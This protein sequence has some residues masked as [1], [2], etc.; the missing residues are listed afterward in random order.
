MKDAKPV[1]VLIG[2]TTIAATLAFTTTAAAANVGV[3]LMGQIGGNF[4]DKPGDRP[5]G[6]P[7]I[8]PGFGGMTAGG[9]LMLDGRILEMLGLEVDVLRTSDKGSGNVTFSAA[10]PFGTI[11]Q[12]EKVTIGQPAWHIP[13]LVKLVVPS[14]LVA[15]EFFLGP[16]LVLPG[17]G[18]VTLDPAVAGVTV[19][20]K[21]DTY[22]MITGGGGVEIKLPLPIL[23]LRIPITLR[24]S[25]NPGLSSKYLDR[26]KI[27]A[28]TGT[29]YDS[30]WK[31]AFNF[32][33]GAAIYF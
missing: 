17:S 26:T 4:Q 7:D 24:G 6:Y 20:A 11:S 19:H 8:N 22:W 25:Y 31:F 32:T 28:T 23:D 13:M 18:S 5:L 12:T 29:T 9:G 14:P 10:T 15:P 2:L 16:E 1:G 21:A 3:G 30:A 33:A 27:N